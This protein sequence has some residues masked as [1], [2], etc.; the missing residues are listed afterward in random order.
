[1]RPQ[2]TQ[3]A[4]RS[5]Q[6]PSTTK[7]K[8]GGVHPTTTL[9]HP[10]A[11]SKPRYLLPKDA[12]WRLA[13][14]PA[15]YHKGD[16]RASG[17]KGTRATTPPPTPT[18]ATS[19]PPWKPC[20]L[21]DLQRSISPEGKRGRA[22]SLETSR[23]VGNSPLRASGS[24]TGLVGGETSRLYKSVDHFPLSTP[25]TK[26]TTPSP[27]QKVSSKKSTSKSASKSSGQ[28]NKKKSTTKSTTKSSS[29]AS[30]KKAG[31]KAMKEEMV[32]LAKM[33]SSVLQ[34]TKSLEQVSE[35]L[36]S[37]AVTL[38]E[39]VLLN[40]SSMPAHQQSLNGSLLRGSG[41]GAQGG[42]VVAGGGSR[43]YASQDPVAAGYSRKGNTEAVP[44]DLGDLSFSST[45]R[46]DQALNNSVQSAGQLQLAD[47]VRQ[48]MHSKLRNILNQELGQG[49]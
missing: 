11:S 31:V 24:G 6:A 14:D 27:S 41:V 19:R 34:A 39:S 20:A 35:R 3:H 40:V 16:V 1:M 43:R 38:S 45:I 48:R 12:P 9:V 5:A 30:S 7:R 37:V 32:A 4:S 25:A 36:K 13:R 46:T 17:G 33:S 15:D 28:S 42:N 18:T 49:I 8:T 26:M 29:K 47:I 22:A 44:V 10:A 21:L 2:T 23:S